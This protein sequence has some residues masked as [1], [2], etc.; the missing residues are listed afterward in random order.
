MQERHISI[1]NALEL[2]LSCTNPSKWWNLNC[3]RMLV[4]YDSY[5]DIVFDSLYYT[6]KYHCRE[7]RLRLNIRNCKS[8]MAIM[9]VTQC[10]SCT[11]TIK[12]DYPKLPF[13]VPH[14]DHVSYLVC[15]LWGLLYH[16]G[17]PAA[18]FYAK[19]AIWTMASKGGLHFTLGSRRHYTHMG[20]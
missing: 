10:F 9:T 3:S 18:I 2:C 14:D 11:V 16:S 20:S 6:W 5:C 17:D 12:A 4:W 8:F 13:A 1:T 7:S 19:L 15:I